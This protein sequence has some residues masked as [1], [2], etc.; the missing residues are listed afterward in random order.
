MLFQI[1]LSPTSLCDTLILQP[2]PKKNNF[3]GAPN[4]PKRGKSLRR[5]QPKVS[6]YNKWANLSNVG[7][8]FFGVFGGWL[9]HKMI[10]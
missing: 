1:V 6:Q 4:K 5:Q 9:I 7:T 3:S 10:C 2:P 8:C